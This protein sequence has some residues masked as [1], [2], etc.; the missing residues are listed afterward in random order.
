MILILSIALMLI[1]FALWHAEGFPAVPK[2]RVARGP[3]YQPANLA[4]TGFGQRGWLQR[5]AAFEVAGQ[6]CW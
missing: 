6:A 5:G 3:P 1:A 4:R 2:C